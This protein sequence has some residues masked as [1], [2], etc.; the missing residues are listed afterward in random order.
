M[1]IAATPED[2]IV[3]EVPLYEAT[4]EGEHCF[5][6]IRKVGRTTESVVRA[7]AGRLDLRARDVGIAGRKDRVAITTQWV[8]VPGVAPERA[9]GLTGEGWEVIDARRH[10]HKL[11]TGQL[12]ANR[13]TLVVREIAPERVE[14]VA[15]RLD[16][17]VRRGMPNRFGLQRFGRAGDNA[18]RG[19]A[20]LADPARSPGRDRRAAR[21]WLSALQSEAFNAFLE[22]RPLAID[23]LGDGEVAYRHDSG[24]SFL[25][26]D[27]QAEAERVERFEISAS[28]PIPGTRLLEAAGDARERERAACA[29]VG[30]PEPLVPPRGIR[31]RGARRPVRVRPTGTGCDVIDT[32]TV[33][34]SFTLPSGSYATVLAEELLG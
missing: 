27:A 32:R 14:G 3:D 16:E 10:P 13:F 31:L 23:A 7:L 28:G 2:F 15:A 19:R 17:M 25:V 22:A 26:E 21:F 12:A 8:S 4:G 6:R 34:L 24:A 20:L 5:L 30:F 33:R 1:R 18:E 29:A 11:R 9:R